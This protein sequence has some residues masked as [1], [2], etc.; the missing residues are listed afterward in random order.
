MAIKGFACPWGQGDVTFDQCLAH[1]RGDPP[2]CGF[3]RPILAGIAGNIRGEM[4]EITVTQ[5]L[6]CL[7]KPVLERRH[8]VYVDPQQLYY[9]FRG[10]M[11]HQIAAGV[12]LSDCVVEQRFR[13]TVAGIVLSG[14]PDLIVP[15]LKKLYDFKTTRQIPKNDR[16]Y[17]NH[18]MQVNI[19]RYLVAPHFDVNEL[20][21]VYM[22]MSQVK[23][24]RVD[25]LSTRRVVSWLV[26]RVKKLR[27]GFDGGTLPE[28]VGADGL[29][30]CNGYCA[31]TASCWPDG[32]PTRG[33][34]RA[35]ERTRRTAIIDAM[36]RRRAS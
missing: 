32:V 24:V 17:A 23:R 25:V 27:Q 21:I 9:A 5:L 34:L 11:F 36:K 22:D 26:P 1:S 7:R 3:T 2:E 8:D 28:R 19:Y 12:D 20:E 15:S 14:Q 6:H 33:Q 35:R 29:W 13:R 18:A 4:E 30:Q 31:F 16:P 10:Q